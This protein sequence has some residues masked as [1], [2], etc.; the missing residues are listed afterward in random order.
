MKK[1]SQKSQW[2]KDLKELILIKSLSPD[3]VRVI[4]SCLDPKSLVN[5]SEAVIASQY[6]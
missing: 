6:Y 5:V 4:F 3:P 2:E 1:E